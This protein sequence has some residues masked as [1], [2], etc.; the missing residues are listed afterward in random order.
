MIEMPLWLFVLIV[1]G[2]AAFN[3]FLMWCN[4]DQAR[5]IR[6]QQRR[7]SPAPSEDPRRIPLGELLGGG[8]L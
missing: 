2:L 7:I 1:A 6:R 5:T 8:Q 3:A 4:H